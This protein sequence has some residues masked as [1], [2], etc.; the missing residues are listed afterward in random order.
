MANKIK[1]FAEFIV[2]FRPILKKMNLNQVE[3]LQNIIWERWDELNNYDANPIDNPK[4]YHQSQFTEYFDEVNENSKKMNKEYQYRTP[5]I[6]QHTHIDRRTVIPD[7]A[8]LTPK[9]IK[10]YTIP[11]IDLNFSGYAYAQILVMME[12]Y[13]NREWGA[14]FVIEHF[15]TIQELIDYEEESFSL[16][17]DRLILYPQSTTSIEVEFDPAFDQHMKEYTEAMNNGENPNGIIHSHHTMFCGHSGTD[18]AML[19]QKIDQGQKT[20]SFVFTFANKM[21]KIDLAQYQFNSD[22]TEEI[23][24]LLDFNVQLVYPNSDLIKTKSEI[25]IKFDTDMTYFDV[26][27][28]DHIIDAEKFLIRYQHMMENITILEPTMKSIAKLFEEKVF[29]EREYWYYYARIHK[30][31][32]REVICK[33][34]LKISN[35]IKKDQ[36]TQDKLEAIKLLLK[37]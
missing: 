31:E 9:L 24:E 16:R 7:Y 28:E 12:A 17:I 27:T 13:P 15:P 19:D 1:S 30:E 22:T 5:A 34:A 26:V 14:Y 33:M 37:E 32:V 21:K 3:D 11:K 20:L 36:D 8:V 10:K 4:N 23:I 25:G 18:M 35:N 6:S 2:K 29:T